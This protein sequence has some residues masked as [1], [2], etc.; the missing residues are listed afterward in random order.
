ME[1]VKLQLQVEVHCV[2]PVKPF[3][4]SVFC[5]DISSLTVSIDG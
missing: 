4:V 5:S 2:V 1:R 3:E